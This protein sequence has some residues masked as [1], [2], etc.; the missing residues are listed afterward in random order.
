[1]HPF[2]LRTPLCRPEAAD[3]RGCPGPVAAILLA[4]VLLLSLGP[5]AAAQGDEGLL[6]G[7]RTRVRTE[8][9]AGGRAEAQRGLLEKIAAA[10]VHF[11]QHYL[12]PSWGQRCAYHPSCS[13]YA[14][15]AIG[16]H[17]ALIG[18]IM[19]FDRLQHEPDE[20]RSAPQVV[21]EGMMKFHDP[22]ENND[23]WWYRPDRFGPLAEGANSP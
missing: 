3:R 6:R 8:A 22:L 18:A 11:Y 2:R 5:L 21:A 13:N 19:T 14:L 4:A 23:Y 9:Q 17:G 16:K 12:G 15:E 7:P 10:P 1:M 20:A